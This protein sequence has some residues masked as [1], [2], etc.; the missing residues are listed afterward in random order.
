MMYKYKLQLIN[1]KN[2]KNKIYYYQKIIIK[3]Y[4]L[5]KLIKMLLNKNLNNLLLYKMK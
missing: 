4:L 2:N 3:I 1:Y 5:I